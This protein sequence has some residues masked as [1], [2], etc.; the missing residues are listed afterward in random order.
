MRL[1]G[2]RH[3]KYREYKNGGISREQFIWEKRKIDRKEEELVAE[4]EK[5]FL[6]LT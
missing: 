4:R 3:G 6:S 1:K 5:I 2:M